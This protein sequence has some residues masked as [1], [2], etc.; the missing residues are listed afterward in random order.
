MITAQSVITRSTL[1]CPRCS[2]ARTE[3]MPADACQYDYECTACHAL[4]TPRSGDC[5]VF[6]SYGDVAC[7]PRQLARHGDCCSADNGGGRD[8]PGQGVAR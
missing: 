5:C 2:V 1:T 3:A 8:M 6:C 7:P 4:L